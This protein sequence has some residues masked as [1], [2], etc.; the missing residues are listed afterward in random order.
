MATLLRRDNVVFEGQPIYA[1]GTAYFGCEF[2]RC[3]IVFKGFPAVF[4]NCRFSGCIWHLDFVL[5]DR[6]QLSA[7]TNFIEQA[8]KPSLTIAPPAASAGA[9]AATVEQP[10][11]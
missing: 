5:H 4:A 11:S 2:R 1:T 9:A 7:M 6:D 3:V 10:T 8:V